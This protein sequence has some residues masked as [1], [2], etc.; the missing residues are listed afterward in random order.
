MNEQNF[1][2]QL[3]RISGEESVSQAHEGEVP[4]GLGTPPCAIVAPDR[5][6][7]VAAIVKI[8]EAEEVAVV[9]SGGETELGT[10]YPLAPD[11]PYL[12]LRTS[13]LNR[14][15]D[16]Q[17]DDLTVTV[18][19][20]VTLAALQQHLASRRLFLPLDVP[21]ADR[22]TMGGIVS[23]GTSGFWRPA[24]GA[25]RDLLIGLRAVMT[26]GVEVKGGGRVVKNVAGYDVCKLFTGA[27]GTLGVLTELTF[28]LRPLPEADRTVSWD[29][30]S[31]QAAVR[32]GLELHQ[33]RLAPTFLVA[34][35]EPEG[36]ARL[37][38]GLQ[39]IAPRVEWQVREFARRL[40]IAGWNSLPNVIPPPELTILRDSL[41]PPPA[42]KRIAL[43]MAVLPSQAISLVSQLAELPGSRLIV[44][45][46][47]G[48]ISL[49]V[50]EADADTVRRVKA[51]VP[52]EANVVWTHLAADLAPQEDIAR[53]G[54]I[55]GE[56]AL[57]HALKLALDPKGTF[58][59]G[60]F[61]G[62][63]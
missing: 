63:L 44:Q 12:L 59:P 29:A 58:S 21:N 36:R 57:H 40:S 1:L 39:G 61:L 15:T 17:P 33:A 20:G 18:E 46:S 54:E 34:T 45:C 6:D 7:V 8:A 4:G 26:G 42:E 43:R 2:E 13:S 25:P 49:T 14:I 35:N 48:I 37:L 62:K 27:R 3:K 30:P 51:L 28:K 11:K 23:G 60:R 10:G 41:N 16:F 56:F 47:T 22:A 24:Y 52:K 31:L 38:I 19:P 50:N 5:T 9:V 53:F 32:L 55:R